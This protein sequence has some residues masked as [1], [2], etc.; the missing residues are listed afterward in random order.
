MAD[1]VAP[2]PQVQSHDPLPEGNWLWRRIF[3]YALC[4]VICL[5]VWAIIQAMI[6]LS[7][8]HSDLT[9]KALKD[10][11][12]W[13]MLLNWFAMT[14]YIVGTN[15]EQ[16]VKIVQTASMFKSGLTTTTTQVATGSDGSK[17]T[18][19]TTTGP[20]VAVAPVA[21]VVAPKG[22]PPEEPQWPR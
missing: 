9:I 3:V 2:P 10:I 5:G 19:T 21:A 14:Y 17:A 4:T 13:M 7:E 22:P 8:N 11:V 1:T 20:A 6:T 12:G 15:A 18:A 16:V